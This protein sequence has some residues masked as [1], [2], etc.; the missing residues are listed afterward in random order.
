MIVRASQRPATDYSRD[1]SVVIRDF[2]LHGLLGIRL[3]GATDHDAAAV[4]RQLGPMQSTLGREPDITIRFVRHLPTPVRMRHLGTHE[5]GYTETGFWILQGKRQ[6]AVRVMLP[7][8]DIGQ[9][10]EIVCQSGLPAVPLLI[11]IINLAL[12]GKGIIA[13]HA[14]AFVYHGVG[15]LVTGWSKG[16]KTETLL[17]LMAAGAEYVGDEWVYIGPEGRTFHGIPEPVRLWDWHLRELPCYRRH[18][19]WQER[20]RLRMIAAARTVGRWLFRRREGH[21][22]AATLV[23]QVDSLL[24]RQLCVDVAPHRL[25]RR[26]AKSLS[27]PFDRLLFLGVHASPDIVVTPTD[28]SE[29]AQR[30]VH[31][32]QEERAPLLSAYRMYRF[33][34]PESRNRLIEDSEDVQR[35]LLIRLLRNKPAYDVLHPYP[36]DLRTLFDKIEELCR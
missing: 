3:I 16:G 10:C 20:G 31:S 24:A 28:P 33:A 29:V 30:M 15:T 19:G 7:W 35:H 25:F 23:R 11:P 13:M 26:T 1:E 36:F 14:S 21:S 32:L 34:C 2:D 18:V 17:T 6:S 5:V 22:R 8:A 27:G 4:A 12:L 9:P